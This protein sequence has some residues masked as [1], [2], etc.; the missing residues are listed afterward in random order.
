MEGYIRLYAYA[1]FVPVLV[2][3][4]AYVFSKF[5]KRGF[6]TKLVMVI[7]TYSMEIYLIYESI[8]NHASALFV[9][10]SFDK[11]GAIYALTVFTATLVLAV[12]LKMVTGQLARV[13]GVQSEK[14]IQ[15]QQ[16]A[17]Q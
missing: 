9:N 4:H 2:L 10:S 15:G 3:A 14:N 5:R 16:E 7:G 8:Y 11:T 6:L 12:L 17:A 1:V 13:F